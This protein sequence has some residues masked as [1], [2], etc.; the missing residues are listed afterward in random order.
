MRDV[1][2]RLEF[3]VVRAPHRIPKAFGVLERT[4]RDAVMGGQYVR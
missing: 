2:V 3:A 4:R 1:V